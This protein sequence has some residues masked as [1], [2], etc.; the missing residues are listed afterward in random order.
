M[1]MRRDGTAAILAANIARLEAGDGG[2]LSREKWL[3]PTFVADLDQDPESFGSLLRHTGDRSASALKGCRVCCSRCARLQEPPTKHDNHNDD[4]PSEA[5]TGNIQAKT[6]SITGGPIMPGH[7]GKHR[8]KQT[9]ATKTHQPGTVPSA[10]PPR[11]LHG[12]G[13]AYAPQARHH[14]RAEG[15]QT[16]DG[17][18]LVST[19][20]ARICA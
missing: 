8:H 17:G 16:A 14:V 5:T 15:G 1:R 12:Q 20:P 2:S 4:A 11:P 6:R 3:S 18:G 19:P 13:D 7:A 9:H 10:T